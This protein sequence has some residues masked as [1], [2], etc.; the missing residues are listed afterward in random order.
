MVNEDRAGFH[1]L[2]RMLKAKNDD[3]LH[4]GRLSQAAKPSCV[5]WSK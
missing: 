4:V 2:T 5:R 3:R 1:E